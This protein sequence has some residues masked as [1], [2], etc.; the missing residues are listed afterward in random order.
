MKNAELVPDNIRTLVPYPPG[1]PLAEL[2][3]ELGVTNAIKLASNENPFGP[4]PLAV[5]AMGKALSELHRYPD[6]GWYYARTAIAK[7]LGVT[8]DQLVLGSGSNEIIELLIR[9]FTDRTHGVLT[10]E[11][12][13]VVYSLISQAHG[14]PFKAVPMKGVAFD[15][16]AIADAVDESTRLIF[17]C[18]PNNPT[19]SWFQQAE[20]DRFLARIGDGPILVLDEAYWEF[21]RPEEQIDSLGVLARRPRTVLLRTFSKAYGLAGIRLGYGVTHPE[22]ASYLDRVRQPFNVNSLAQASAVAALAD[23]D[24]L[25]HVLTTT[26]AGLHT[27]AAGLTALGLHPYPSS[28]NFILFDC[29]KEAWPI[30]EALLRKGVIVRPMKA[31]GL[32]TH[33]RVTIGTVEENDRFLRGLADVLEP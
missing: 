20:L 9:T 17:L 7:H 3:R 31:Y 19:G 11:T 14:A 12:T 6:G 22:L 32:P 30:Y 2:E 1:K 33:L 28:A 26:R 10:S 5:Q 27:V 29:H 13:F 24:Y 25:G 21:V 8:S 16:D 4:S 15:L 18:N 23:H